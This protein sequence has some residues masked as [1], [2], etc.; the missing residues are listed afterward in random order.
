[1]SRPYC[2]FPAKAFWRSGTLPDDDGTIAGLYMPKF[3]I[4]ADTGIATAG[5]CFAQHIGAA[6][7]RADCMI[8]DTEPPLR[9]MPET[10]ARHYGYGIYSAR[11]G[12]IYTPRQLVELLQEVQAPDPDPQLVWEHGGQY[13]DALRPAVE[14]GGLA[15]V[16]EVLDHRR[17]HL[18]RV[19]QLFEQTDIFIFTL[20]LTEAWI[21]LQTGRT[22]P[23]CPGVIAGQFD[24]DRHKLQQFSFAEI[25]DDLAQIS[26]VLQ[27]F[28]PD[29][30]LLLTVSPVPLTATATG[31]HVLAATTEAKSTLRAAAGAYV[32]GNADA[33]Y[34]PAYEIVTS[35][36]AGGPW[37][38]KDQ[39]NVASEG[40]ARVMQ[41]FFAAHGLD[42]AGAE[43]PP[44]TPE[45]DLHC[46]E[47]MLQ[48][49]AP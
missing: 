47:A 5:S 12:N 26:A 29:M 31:Q 13:Y 46:E 45:E 2:D 40:V 21:D 3:A 10:V 20:G 44:D 22:L 1:M 16:Q 48:V 19:S 32:Q 7:R 25:M 17:F 41:T 24:P 30:K 9:R 15:T 28:Q 11:Y 35:A 14:P 8:V 39:R 43:A 23:V 18:M 36:V 49:F 6:L 34:F 33:D 27:Q 38:A 37:F 42:M 4:D